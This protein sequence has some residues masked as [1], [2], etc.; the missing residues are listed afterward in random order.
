MKGILNKEGS[1]R[2]SS[3]KLESLIPLII[4]KPGIN[5]LFKSTSI[6]ECGMSLECK[7]LSLWTSTLRV[8]RIYIN[9]ECYVHCI[10]CTCLCKWTFVNNDDCPN[11]FHKKF[12]I[13]NKSKVFSVIKYR[14]FNMRTMIKMNCIN[15]V[16]INDIPQ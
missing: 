11:K 3:D 8:I 13:Q 5:V 6:L 1:N 2:S 16:K 12:V 10:V 9:I 15:F 7:L 4:A 14:Y